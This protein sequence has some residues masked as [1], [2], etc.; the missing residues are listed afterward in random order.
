MDNFSFFHDIGRN[1]KTDIENFIVFIYKRTTVN[2]GFLSSKNFHIIKHFLP[3]G[4]GEEGQPQQFLVRNKNQE[5]KKWQ[6]VS[7]KNE[8][9]NFS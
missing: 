7:H 4:R 2:T 9:K 1:C 3:T 5:R 8:I 6:R